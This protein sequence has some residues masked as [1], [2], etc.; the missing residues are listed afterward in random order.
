VAYD[1]AKLLES[2]KGRLGPT[3]AADENAWK[4][5]VRYAAGTR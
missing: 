3:S 4:G 5:N 1:P 2:V